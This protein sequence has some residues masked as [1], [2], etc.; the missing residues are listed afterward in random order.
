MKKYNTL[1][2]ICISLTLILAACSH[3]SDT[4]PYY[5]DASFTPNWLTEKTSKGF[6]SIPNFSLTNQYGESISSADLIGK[7]YV[8]DFFFTTCPGICPKMTE[9]MRMVQE[10]FLTDDGVKI[11][12]FSVTPEMDSVSVL[13][14]YAERKKITSPN[15]HLLTGDRDI[16]YTLGRKSYFVEEDLGIDKKNEDFLHTENF[17]LIDKN[18]HIRGIYNGLNKASVNQ[19][20]EDIRLLKKM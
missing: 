18:A 5:E 13:Q 20:I 7:V 2:N 6:H 12:S 4:L 3:T 17:V 10:A 11:L 16:I 15:W 8:A 1:N 14:A 9:N 19:L